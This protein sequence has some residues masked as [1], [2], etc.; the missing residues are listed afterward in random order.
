MRTLLIMLFLVFTIS[1][2][3]AC[4]GTEEQLQQTEKQLQQLVE[5]E[6]IVSIESASQL[7]AVIPS[8]LPVTSTVVV[9]GTPV[10]PPLVSDPPVEDPVVDP[11]PPPV[12]YNYPPGTVLVRLSGGGDSV[13]EGETFI[14]RVDIVGVPEDIGEI[15]AGGCTINMQD[16]SGRGD[17]RE[18]QLGRV[19]FSTIHDNHDDEGR[20]ALVTILDCDLPDLN[21]AGIRYEI[22]RNNFN[23]Q[24]TI[25]I[26]TAGPL[27]DGIDDGTYILTLAN[28]GIQGGQHYF[29]FV[30]DNEFPAEVNFRWKWKIVYH[31]VPDG[32]SPPENYLDL[33]TLN[34]DGDWEWHNANVKSTRR[35]GDPRVG[36]NGEQI[37][38]QWWT[39]RWWPTNVERT[40]TVTITRFEKHPLITYD[41]TN[42]DP[43]C[44][45]TPPGG[46]YL[47]GE[48]RTLTITVPAEVE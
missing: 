34:G 32:T 13:Q 48:P 19:V 14:V 21:D 24:V 27:D 47:I 17:R 28:L 20:T 11:D 18:D 45:Y 41:C 42:G 23:H 15:V 30:V 3:T 43:I 22:D 46:T 39:M 44:Y 40:L 7:P 29:N 6:A 33:F 9:S 38:T 35:F 4:T 12:S 8:D 26:T 5:N 37:Y 10:V 1:A 16:N 31:D 2:F 25:D 36:G